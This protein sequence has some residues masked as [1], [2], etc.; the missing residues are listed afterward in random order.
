M[1]STYGPPTRAPALP[2][3]C[4]PKPW[5]TPPPCS[6][7]TGTTRGPRPSTSTTGSFPTAPRRTTPRASWKSGWF[8]ADL[9]GRGCW[10]PGVMSRVTVARPVRRY[11][12]GTFVSA[13]D[14]VAG[15]EPLEL[16]V[17]GHRLT[18]TMR[19]PGHDVEL[20]HGYLFAEGVI[21]VAS[22]VRT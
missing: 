15:E 19:T 14:T 13:P 21:A 10:H 3:N 18:L 8:V 12:D 17:G 6:G 16:R 2:T 20:V 1:R 5:A 4:W 9:P 22:D 11:A 7:S